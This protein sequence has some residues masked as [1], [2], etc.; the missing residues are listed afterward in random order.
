[1]EKLV[2]ALCTVLTFIVLY[3]V[4]GSLAPDPSVRAIWA[5][6]F[7]AGFSYLFFRRTRNSKD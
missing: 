3:A 1:M 2:N 5:A 4:M 6:L 7:A